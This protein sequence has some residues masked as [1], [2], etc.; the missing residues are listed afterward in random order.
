M[1]SWWGGH[2]YVNSSVLQINECCRRLTLPLF[3]PHA[4]IKDHHDP[5]VSWFLAKLIEF[6][7]R[8]NWPKW[9]RIDQD[10]YELTKWVRIDRRKYWWILDR[11]ISPGWPKWELID[12]SKNYLRYGLNSYRYE[13]LVFCTLQ[14][15]IRVMYLYSFR[16]FWFQIFPK[17]VVGLFISVNEI[18]T[19]YTDIFAGEKNISQENYFV[20]YLYF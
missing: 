4:G 13:Y 11:K 8:T 18:V 20:L 17:I 9:K 6:S 14:G 12:L 2:E 5:L 15:Y 1:F 16:S 10:E 7:L 19:E 3:S